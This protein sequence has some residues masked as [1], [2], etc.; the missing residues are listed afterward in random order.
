MMTNTLK[1]TTPS[2]T[3]MRGTSKVGSKMANITE[4]RFNMSLSA[5][6]DD[7]LAD[8]AH[9]RKVSKAEVVRNLIDKAISIE[10]TAGS[11][12]GGSS[13]AMWCWCPRR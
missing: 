2:G 6:Q 12:P 7:W 11:T 5:R 3:P 4:R 8:Q 9:S 13:R 1:T 10:E